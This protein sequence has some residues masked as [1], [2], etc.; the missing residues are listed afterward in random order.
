MVLELHLG[1]ALEKEEYLKV[2]KR[3]NYSLGSVY[4]RIKELEKNYLDYK[5]RNI[6]SIDDVHMDEELMNIAQHILN[7][8]LSD[9]DLKELVFYTSSLNNKQLQLFAEP[10]TEQEYKECVLDYADIDKGDINLELERLK[11]LLPQEPELTETQPSFTTTGFQ[12]R[13]PAFGI[14]VKRV[15]DNTCAICG[16]RLKSPEGH[17]E[18]QGAHIYPKSH[19]GK[20]DVRNG[21]CLC[22]MHHWAFDVGW[23]SI[24]DDYTVLGKP[25]L[26][27]EKHYNFIRDYIGRKIRLPIEECFK[28]HPIYLSAYRKLMNF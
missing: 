16:S 21:I 23:I 8:E 28:P 6:I 17:Y 25:N 19:N 26:P 14:G 5:N 13:N 4:Y 15:Y 27:Q 12:K 22:R 18:V 1:R 2:A 3:F 10:V 20:D 7:Q 24:S 11:N 9:A